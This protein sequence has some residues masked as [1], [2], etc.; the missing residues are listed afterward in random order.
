MPRI[1]SDLILFDAATVYDPW[2]VDHIVIPI[3]TTLNGIHP[4]YSLL[5]AYVWESYETLPHRELSSL[6]DSLLVD[7]IQ[8][9]LGAWAGWMFCLEKKS[10]L[11]PH[12]MEIW[13]D[14]RQ[15]TFTFT[16]LGLQTLVYIIVVTSIRSSVYPSE[17][18]QG[19][20]KYIFSSMLHAL[21][22]FYFFYRT[23]KG[24]CKWHLALPIYVAL[25]VLIVH[26]ITDTVGNTFHVSCVYWG[27]F[28]IIVSAI[29]MW[30]QPS[31]TY[32]AVETKTPVPDDGRILQFSLI[33]RVIF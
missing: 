30:Q 22:M 12:A 13:N 26:Y 8:A 21:F 11:W 2:S 15:G 19:P 23:Q 9:I 31:K 7:P 28:N 27:A 16:H 3:F 33:K 20:K 29:L 14:I 1:E 24:R 6:K 10:G 4:V 17:D 25:F 18:V 5:F 32:T